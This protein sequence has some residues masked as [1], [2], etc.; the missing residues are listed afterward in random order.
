MHKTIKDIEAY[1][2]DQGADRPPCQIEF[3]TAFIKSSILQDN[4]IIDSKT[5]YDIAEQQWQLSYQMTED[6][7]VSYH[8]VSQ[9]S[10]HFQ[11]VYALHVASIDYK[12]LMRSI[13]LVVRRSKVNITL[14][15]NTS[16]FDVCRD[17]QSRIQSFGIKHKN[18]RKESHYALII[19][20]TKSSDPIEAII[21]NLQATLNDLRLVNN[22]WRPVQAKLMHAID[23]INP[24]TALLKVEKDD[25]IQLIRWIHDRYNL[26]GY[27]AFKYQKKKKSFHRLPLESEVLGV[28]HR[29]HQS[30]IRTYSAGEIVNKPEVNIYK[31]QTKATL[32]SDVY[33]NMITISFNDN[34]SIYEYQFLGLFPSDAYE[35][36][37]L[38]IPW[39]KSK[40][41]A[42]KTLSGYKNSD[43][44][45]KAILKIIRTLPRDELFLSDERQLYNLVV[46][47]YTHQGRASI[48]VITR[49]NIH[50]L[51]LSYYV[52]MP[53]DDFSVRLQKNVESFLSNRLDAKDVVSELILTDLD[54][55]ILYIQVLLKE[56]PDQETSLSFEDDI[57]EICSDWDNNLKQY[58]LKDFNTATAIQLYDLYASSLSNRYKKLH[59]IQETIVDINHLELLSFERPVIASIVQHHDESIV[60]KIYHQMTGDCFW[61]LSEITN[62][63]MTMGISTLSEESHRVYQHGYSSFIRILKVDLPDS[64]KENITQHKEVIEQLF[65]A[66]LQR[67]YVSDSLNQ[68]SLLGGFSLQQINLFRAYCQYIFQHN[69]T[70]SSLDA[71][72]QTLIDNHPIVN[73]LYQLFQFMHG[74]DSNNDLVDALQEK[75]IE[76]INSV[77]SLYMDKI[78]RFVFKA[79]KATVRTNY[80]IESTDALILKFLNLKLP[81]MLEPSPMYEMFVYHHEFIAIHLRISQ[82]SRGGIRW[83]DQNEGLREEIHALMTAQAVKNS[84]IVPDGAKGGF[85]IRKSDVSPAD[86]QQCYRIFI[87]AMLSITD[88]IV[89]DRIIP[90]KGIICLDDTDSYLVVAADK[91][92]ANLSDTANQI[93]HDNEYWLSDGFA[94]GGRDGYN[95]KSMAITARTAWNSALWHFRTLEHDLSKKP[96]SVVGIGDMSGDVFGNGMLLSKHIKLIAV[97]NHQHIFIDPSPD[98]EVSYQ[99]RQRLFNG[100]KGWDAYDKTLLS[101]GGHVYQRSAK[102]IALSEQAC[103]VLNL[104]PSSKLEPN[105]VIKAI[106]QSDVDLLFNGGIG[107]YVKASWETN[108]EVGDKNNI[109][110]RINASSLRVK[111]VSEGGNLGLTQSAR[112]EYN[113]NGGLINADFID[114]LGG[115]DCSDK[116]VNIK[117]LFNDLIN[118]GIL[119]LKERNAFMNSLKPEIIKMVV[120]DNED[121]NMIISTTLYRISQSYILFTRYLDEQIEEKLLDQDTLKLPDTKVLAE[122]RANGLSFT[123]PEIAIL[124]AHAKK[125]AKSELFDSEIIKLESAKAFLYYAF[126]ESMVE[127]YADKI[128]SH[129]LRDDII[130]TEISNR[131]IIETGV[132][133]SMQMREELGVDGK[134]TIKSYIFARDILDMTSIQQYIDSENHLMSLDTAFYLNS[135]IRSVLREATRWLLLSNKATA[136]RQESIIDYQQCLRKL[137]DKM[138]MLQ[139]FNKWSNYQKLQESLSQSQVS[140]A[141]MT[142]LVSFFALT[143]SLDM[144]VD[145]VDHHYDID[146]YA[147]T[148]C[149]LDRYLGT[150][151]FMSAVHDYHTKST[152]DAY[153]CNSLLDRMSDIRCGLIR[154]AMHYL[155]GNDHNLLSLSKRILAN[156]DLVSK[157]EQWQVDV[158]CV[159]N[160][161]SFTTDQYKC[162][163]LKFELLTRNLL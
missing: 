104:P 8:E 111:V 128:D 77:T 60:F 87:Q 21:D 99:E 25:M 37:P 90:P 82:K 91:G 53:I 112:S 72:Y 30:K 141:M 144:V 29:K 95:H 56:L 86:I 97:F 160:Q 12:F 48:K 143:R 35:N 153:A 118:K 157:L 45:I 120:K 119:T 26:F 61:R 69:I 46:G 125:Q 63:L 59:T 22:D 106:L 1:L 134:S 109:P 124:I 78:L 52:L 132:A 162:Y 107:T 145:L 39:L 55:A 117:I 140:E 31:T 113:L 148:F 151:V 27:R 110:L 58:L 102:Q 154:R 33:T 15:L 47:I 42:I 101:E 96:I 9:L 92:T 75:I 79:I 122:R 136:I 98:P 2:I 65:E 73:D 163:L 84:V 32:H 28:L 139:Q 147:D 137:S 18:S 3:Y 70:T 16:G 24:D 149:E 11:P 100:S 43:Y 81:G 71:F 130:A 17:D 20:L 89:Q 51:T 138:G 83:S 5:L 116:E 4:I 105:D 38:T 14:I 123:R 156:S 44:G 159:S 88:N 115:V 127:K 93:A 135:R 54:Q 129:Y 64:R 57:R 6:Y 94:S 103:F 133:F 80:F 155:S 66:I 152:W 49:T 142:R 36:D 19:E 50:S 13:R 114:N 74:M 68:L 121:Q 41:E 34:E 146:L 40:I 131:F 150:H 126:P 76:S 10:Q 62:I 23:K 7:G 67:Q 161:D 158:Q 85:F 108:S